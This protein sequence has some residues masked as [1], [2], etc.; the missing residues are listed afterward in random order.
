MQIVEQT[1]HKGSIVILADPLSI[2]AMSKLLGLTV[3]VMY[4]RLNALH[5]ILNV[6]RGLQE[7]V[8]LLHISV[9]DYFTDPNQGQANDF[10]VDEQC[11]Q[12]SLL[13]SCMLI[14]DNSL[15]EDICDLVW[16]A[17]Q[18]TDIPSERVASCIPGELQYACR[19]WVYHFQKDLTPFA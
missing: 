15:R 12:L 1:C 8:R 13:K 17:T 2:M 11:I 18:R 6:P 14:M 9:R 3:R 19:H 16:P 10:W 5:S 7:T 4:S